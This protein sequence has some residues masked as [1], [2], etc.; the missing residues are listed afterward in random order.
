[1]P[2]YAKL[3]ELVSHRIRIDY[4]TGARIV[5][6]VAQVR[7][8]VGQVELLLLSRAEIYGSDGAL[9]EQHEQMSICPNVPSAFRLDEGPVGRSE[10]PKPEAVGRPS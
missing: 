8:A 7:P 6:Y 9:Y 5:G 10:G 1:M 4:D 2:D 3:R